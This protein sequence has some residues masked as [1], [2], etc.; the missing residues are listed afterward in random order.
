MNSLTK[1]NLGKNIGNSILKHKKSLATGIAAL[2]LPFI[3]TST[4]RAV[5]GSVSV[6][7]GFT[8]KTKNP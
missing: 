5:T 8:N 6:T 2:A 7:Y 3:F 4:D 1:S